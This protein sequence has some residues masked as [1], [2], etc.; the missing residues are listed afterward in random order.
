MK[1]ISLKDFTEQEDNQR[2][3][4]RVLCDDDGLVCF[5]CAGNYRFGA[6]LLSERGV[7]QLMQTKRRSKHKPALVLVCSPDML[8][9]VVKEVPEQ[10]RKLLQADLE[11]RLTVKLPL[12]KKLPRKVYRDLSKPDGK[13]GVRLPK[14]PAVASLVKA[15]G[16]PVLVS[17]ANRSQKTGAASVASIR[18]QFARNIDLFI[19]AGD[20][21]TQPPS[22]VVEIDKKGQ[23]KVVRAGSVT[24]EQIRTLLNGG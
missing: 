8:V 4:A 17:S 19:E 3:A 10:A 13:V 9:D 11:G 22:T 6:N 14:S 24:E 2:E 15:A 16:V 23:V 20:L 18:Q 7:L 5:P 21:P 12:S 1:Q